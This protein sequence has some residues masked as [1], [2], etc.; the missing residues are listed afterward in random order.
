MT[1]DNSRPNQPQQPPIRPGVL[2]AGG[3]ATAVVAALVAAVGVVVCQ[4]VFSINLLHIGLPGNPHA[5]NWLA[6]P[7]IG[8][9]VAIIAT[10]VLHLLLTLV[11]QPTRFFNWIMALVTVLAAALP[12]V[13]GVS[14]RSIVTAVVDVL[15]VLAIWLLLN[16]TAARARRT[17]AQLPPDPPAGGYPPA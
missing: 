7:V 4:A 10:G 11:P 2:W 14:A 8:F 13:S 12:F 1:I 3:V 6:Y 16:G 5:A 15:T 9:V 17:A